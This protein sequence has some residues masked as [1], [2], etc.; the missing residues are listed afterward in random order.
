M[1]LNLKVLISIFT[2]HILSFPLMTPRMLRSVNGMLG[3][4]EY[5]VYFTTSCI[6]WTSLHMCF[7]TFSLRLFSVRLCF[8]L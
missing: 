3:D 4:V 7:P 5:I 2:F 1:Y 8:G 6:A